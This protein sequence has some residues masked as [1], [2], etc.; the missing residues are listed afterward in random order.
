MKNFYCGKIRELVVGG[1]R[2]GC[3]SPDDFDVASKE[4]ELLDV[5]LCYMDELAEN[6]EK[7]N[8]KID[9]LSN[10]LETIERFAKE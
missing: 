10:K 2:E 8:N 4:V 3:E 5:C 9:D 1:I 6:I 7:L